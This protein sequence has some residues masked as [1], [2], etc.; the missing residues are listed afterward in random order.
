MKL[1]LLALMLSAV[2]VRDEDFPTL[3]DQILWKTEHEVCAAN[4]YQCVG[5]GQMTTRCCRVRVGLI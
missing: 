3:S 5:L 4:P 1:L 2:P